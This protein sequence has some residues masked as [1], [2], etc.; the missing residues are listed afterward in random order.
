MSE[1]QEFVIYQNL[2]LQPTFIRNN[3]DDTSAATWSGLKLEQVEIDFNPVDYGRK[4]PSVGTVGPS[5]AMEQ[6]PRDVEQMIRET[7]DRKKRDCPRIYN[8]AKLRMAEVRDNMT[9]KIKIK[10]K[11]W[12]NYR[13]TIVRK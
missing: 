10:R 11:S 9:F 12:P 8:M 1:K 5:G 6:S 3:N 13:F 4:V 2:E 7:W